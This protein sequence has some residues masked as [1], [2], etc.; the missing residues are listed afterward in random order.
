MDTFKELID[1]AHDR[2]IKIMVDVVLNHAGYGLKESDEQPGVTAEDKARFAGM[3]R[4]DGVQADKDVIRGELSGLPDFRTEDPAVREKL[5]AWQTGWLNNARTERGDT[6]DYFRV[7]TVK[8]VEDTT[9]KA[10]KNALATIDPSFKLVGEYFGGTAGNDGGTLESGQ[11]DGLLDFGFKEQAKRFTG[12]SIT[13][14]DAYLQEREAKIGNTRMMAQFLSSHDEDGFL[15]EYVDGDEGK[16]KVAAALQITAKGQPVVYYGEELGRSGKNAGNMAE[17]E[18]SGNRS[19]MPW[20]QL[21]AEQGLHDHYKKLLNIRANYSEVYARGTRSWLAGNDESGYLA[22]N[23]QYGK[24]NIVTVINSKAEGQK[25]EIPVPY[26][27]LS[28]VKDEY[29]G[30]E[31]TVSAAGKVSIDLPGRDAGGTVILSAKSE[32]VVPTP[33]PTATP[34][35]GGESGGTPLVTPSPSSP[36]VPGDIQEVS[37]AQLSSATDGRVELRMEPGKTAVLLPLQAAGLLGKN[38]LVIQSEGLSVTVP[39]AV[40]ADAEALVKK[41][42]AESTRILLE[43]RP[44]SPVAVQEEVRR[45]STENRLASA[46]SGIYELKLQ[47]VKHDGTR[48]PV[49][50]FKQPVTLTLKLTGHPTKDWTGVFSLEDGGVLRYMG[51]QSRRTVPTRRQLHNPAGMRCLRCIPSLRMYRALTGL[52]LQLHRWLRSKSL[53]V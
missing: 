1:K 15:S 11:M 42:D 5:I 37:E 28:A 8:H 38:E 52:L 35:P 30:K 24:T 9:W 27:P 53:P 10:F 49:N 51:E 47:L 45:L 44:L 29:S 16:L 32:A 43:L 33:V 21:D 3:L 31:Y 26:E 2:G 48:L 40:L 39:S 34:V 22:F 17:G 20:D 18:F 23:K 41:A 36:A 6:I 7:D 12:G 25:A 14:V 46:A 19:D 13:A 4:T 50:S